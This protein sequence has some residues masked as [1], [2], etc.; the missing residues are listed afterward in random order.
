MLFSRLLSL[1]RFSWRALARFWALGALLPMLLLSIAGNVPHEHELRALSALVRPAS[2]VHHSRVVASPVQH[3]D[4]PHAQKS[5]FLPPSLVAHPIETLCLLC[6]WA[7]VAGALLF[8][9]L[10]LSWFV[11]R[12]E[13]GAFTRSVVFCFVALSLRSRAPPV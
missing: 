2:G 8:V 6:Q 7:S 4:V 12:A 10:A 5:A 1:P 9:A 13:V 11:T 3:G